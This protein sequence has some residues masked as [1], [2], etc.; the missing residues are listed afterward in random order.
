MT[1][2]ASPSLQQFFRAQAIKWSSAGLLLTVGFAVPCVLYSAKTASERQVLL[3]AKS[4]ARAFRPLILQ[5]AVRDAEF[6]MKASLELKKGETALILDPSFQPIYPLDDTGR[7]R[8]KTVGNY[9]WDFSSRQ[10]SFLYPIYF[11][12]ER[13]TDLYG[14]LAVTLNATMDYSTLLVLVFLLLAAFVGQAFGLSSALSQSARLLAGRLNT[15]AEYLKRTPTASPAPLPV[16][17]FTELSGM[18]DAVDTLHVE[19]ERLREQT[20]KEATV[21]AQFALLREIGHDLRTPHSQLAKYFA[22]HLDTVR[23]TG[24]ANPDEVTRVERTLKRMGELIRQ[25]RIFQDKPTEVGKDQERACSLVTEVRTI[26]AD[27][28]NDPE[29]LEKHISVE[30][31][32]NGSPPIAKISKVGF[33]RITENLLRNALQAVQPGAGK[34]VI[35]IATRDGCPTLVVADNG[36]G[37]PLEVQSKIFDF[38]FTTKPS[39]GTGLGLGIVHRICEQF[40]A[41]ISF[42]TNVG[43][44]TKFTV[45]F[46][47]AEQTR[48][49]HPVASEGVA[50]A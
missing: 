43:L 26:H 9:C 20:A 6:Q 48:S 22:L 21:T 46:Q 10:L 14:Y 25:V 36:S 15:W 39:R 1:L 49:E 34:L 42:E 5:G 33:Y 3:V 17:P 44:G 23:T 16:V 8:C 12:E 4:A 28:M 7:A 13:K 29:F 37:I 31:K 11:D 40:G 32:L 30:L 18:Q 38:D 45:K 2:R 27:L 24:R 19:I 50:H 47:R 41:D 35:E